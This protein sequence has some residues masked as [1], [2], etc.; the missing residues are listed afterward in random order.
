MQCRR[1]VSIKYKVINLSVLDQASPDP[2]LT[3]A[4]SRDYLEVGNLS[5]GVTVRSAVTSRQSSAPTAPGKGITAYLK[6]GGYAGEVAA[7]A[8]HASTLTTQLHC[9]RRDEVGLDKVERIAIQEPS[10]L[11]QTAHYRWVQRQRQGSDP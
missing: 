9:R 3:G 8:N 5:L 1:F 4:A 11:G 7:I 10:A 6:N 2:H